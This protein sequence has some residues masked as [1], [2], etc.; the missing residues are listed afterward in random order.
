MTAVKEGYTI[1]V[2]A[3]E[4]DP[5]IRN[6]MRVDVIN[7]ITIDK[8]NYAKHLSF[9]I[10]EIP[11]LKYYE[12]VCRKDPADGKVK[13]G[14]W[15]NTGYDAEGNP[16]WKYKNPIKDL[17]DIDLNYYLVLDP[18][19]ISNLDLDLTRFEGR[20]SYLNW[21]TR[22]NIRNRPGENVFLIAN[23]NDAE[24]FRGITAPELSELVYQDKNELFIYQINDPDAFKSYLK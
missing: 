8:D 7:G 11:C 18:A 9:S 20:L 15:E 14:E 2:A 12:G 23:Y 4:S 21:L 1:I 19:G 22:K 24:T 13:Y 10:R 5:T 6:T 16:V 17:Y 3:S